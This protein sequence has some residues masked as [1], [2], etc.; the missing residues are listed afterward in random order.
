MWETLTR[1]QLAFTV[2]CVPFQRPEIE[3]SDEW[4]Y[5]SEDRRRNGRL[6]QLHE[7]HKCWGSIN[8]P[9][10]VLL[11]TQYLLYV[12]GWLSDWLVS[13]LAGNIWRHINHV[14]PLPFFCHNHA[15]PISIKAPFQIKKKNNGKRRTDKHYTRLNV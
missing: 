10:V 1:R 15:M 13:W 6:G 5:Q 14:V 4:K 9:M 3:N 11:P 7:W 12:Y 8:Y 2:L